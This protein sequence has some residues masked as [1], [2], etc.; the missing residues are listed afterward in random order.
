MSIVTLRLPEVKRKTKTRPQKCPY[1]SGNT[2]QSWGQS[3]NQ[4]EIFAAERSVSAATAVVIAIA[5]FATIQKAWTGRPNGAIAQVCSYPVGVRH[6]FA[7]SPTGSSAFNLSIS[8]M[9]VWRDL[10]EQAELVKQRRK[11]QPVRIL[12][13]DGSLSADEGQE[14]AH[15]CCHRHG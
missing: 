8:H 9:T 14:A 15:H 2:F 6:E 3:P 11:W 1:C 5:P 7:V 4:F 10:Q 12:G 13:V